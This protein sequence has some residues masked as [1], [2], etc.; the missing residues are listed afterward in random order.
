MGVVNRGER[1]EL[2][3]VQSEQSSVKSDG[4]EEQWRGGAMEGPLREIQGS[5]LGRLSLWHIH[6]SSLSQQAEAARINLIVIECQTKDLSIA[7]PVTMFVC[8]STAIAIFRL[9]EKT[10][11]QKNN[12]W[13]GGPVNCPSSNNFR[14]LVSTT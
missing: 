4:G 7:R 6:L 10:C 13:N 1:E 2:L 14:V 12:W 9:P 5:V 11:S 8:T 3:K